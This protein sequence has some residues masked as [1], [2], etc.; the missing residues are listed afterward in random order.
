V[1]DL[2]WFRGVL[3]ARLGVV[4]ISIWVAL[5]TTSERGVVYILFVSAL[6]ALLIP[7]I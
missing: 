3:N 1:H 7:S 2:G 5:I 6:S 4:A